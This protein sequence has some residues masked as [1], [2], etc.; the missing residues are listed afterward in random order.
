MRVTCSNDSWH[1]INSLF[2]IL[3]ERVDAFA[4]SLLL[5]FADL[6]SKDDGLLAQTSVASGFLLTQNTRCFQL[7]DD[8]D[9]LHPA[10]IQKPCSRC[11][12]EAQLSY[13][14]RRGLAD[15]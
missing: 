8:V 9:N 1:V 2:R 6:N 10:A 5:V 11:F 3:D 15:V 13:P 12:H 14:H 4:K 7:L